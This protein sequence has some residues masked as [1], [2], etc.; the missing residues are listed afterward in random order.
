MPNVTQPSETNGR[1]RKVTANDGSSTRQL[2]APKSSHNT[3]RVSCPAAYALRVF[4][5]NG[6]D[7]LV[8]PSIVSVPFVVPTE[9]HIAAYL[10]D[11]VRAVQAGDVQHLRIMHKS[12]VSLN[13]C[14][15]FGESLIATA[16][17]RGNLAVVRFLVLEAKVSLLLRDDFNRTVLHD[18]FWT[19][20]PNVELVEFLLRIVPDLLCVKDQR[21]HAP[22]D[23]VRSEHWKRWNEFIE[24]RR[25]LFCLKFSGRVKG[26]AP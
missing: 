25:N 7:V 2:K 15:R 22:L 3:L 9:T 11:T 26:E 14:N 21:G 23:Y 5:E 10:T 4:Q 18:A 1:K 20:E 17:R 12:G 13:C 16:C 6:F 24:E 8:D 19:P